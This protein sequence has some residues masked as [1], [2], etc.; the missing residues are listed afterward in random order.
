MAV[1]GFHLSVNAW[2]AGDWVNPHVCE[3]SSGLCGLVAQAVGGTA[4]KKERV[5][6]QER[7]CLTSQVPKYRPAEISL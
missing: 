4:F 7:L 6:L 5:V 1:V 3:S 2:R